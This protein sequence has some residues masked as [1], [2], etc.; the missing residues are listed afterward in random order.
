MSINKEILW[1]DRYK[2]GINTI[3]IQHKQ[4]FT[5]VN[6]LYFLDNIDNIKEEFKGILNEFK[7][8]YEKSL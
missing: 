2:L 3:D 6:K 5:L 1:D 7:W 4:L 8:I